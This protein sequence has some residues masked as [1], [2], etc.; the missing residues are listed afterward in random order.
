[1]HVVPRALEIIDD[2]NLDQ[3]DTLEQ[4]C[5]YEHSHNITKAGDTCSDIM[6]YIR[7]VSGF[8]LNYNTRIFDY[9]W[10][11]IEAPYVN[12]L[13]NSSRMD[14]LYAAIH[15]NGSYKTPVF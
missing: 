13:S 6:G 14:E 15:V 10:D 11:P 9:D 4:R 1:M 8:V 2:T 7:H 5:F 12:M 3:I